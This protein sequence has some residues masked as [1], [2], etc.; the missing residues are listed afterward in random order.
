MHCKIRMKSMAA[1]I[2]TIMAILS[3]DQHHHDHTVN[4][5]PPAFEHRTIQIYTIE[6]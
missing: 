6:H 4:S 5:K 1:M 3:C 2:T